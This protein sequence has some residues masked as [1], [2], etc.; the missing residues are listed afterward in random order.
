MFF[1]ILLFYFM[2]A[3]YNRMITILLNLHELQSIY[4]YIY[5]ISMHNLNGKNV[6]IDG[7]TLAWLNERIYIT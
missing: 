4:I 6:T 3:D 7:L 5:M 2:Y 1:F